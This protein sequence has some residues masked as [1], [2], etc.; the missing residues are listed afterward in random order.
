[1]SRLNPIMRRQMGAI[2]SGLHQDLT[3]A[4]GTIGRGEDYAGAVKEY[5]R[6]MQLRKAAI[7][8]AKY[9]AGAAGLGIAGHYLKD[10]IPQR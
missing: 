9:G 10:L 7:R 4:A 1:V 8:A 6:A 3:D 5:A 2:R